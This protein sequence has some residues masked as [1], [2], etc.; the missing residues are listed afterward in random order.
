LC[1]NSFIDRLNEILSKWPDFSKLHNFKQ[2]FQEL[3]PYLAVGFEDGDL[4]T[5]AGS[6][7]QTLR[8]DANDKETTIDFVAEDDYSYRAILVL[9]PDAAWRL[10]SIKPQCAAC[11]GRGINDGQKCI[12]C[13]GTGWH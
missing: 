3:K 2:Q 5:I 10:R 12:I 11:F 8:L 9:G 6:A 4:T 13:D 1:S 7:K